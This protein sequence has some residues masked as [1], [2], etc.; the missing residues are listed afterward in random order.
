[1]VP[2]PAKKMFRKFPAK[3]FNKVLSGKKSILSILIKNKKG[4]RRKKK[5]KRKKEK[6]KKEKWK[7]KTAK[8]RKEKIIQRTEKKK[9]K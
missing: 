3:H 5:Y 4:K 2:I 9:K 8:K 7:R 1:M 6:K